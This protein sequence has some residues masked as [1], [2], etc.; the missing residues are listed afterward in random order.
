VLLA[1]CLGGRSSA[2]QYMGRVAEAADDGRLSLALAQQAGYPGAEAMALA[3]LSGAAWYSGDR[4]GAIRLAHQAQQ[5]RGEVP[6]ALYRA[7]SQILTMVLTG[8]GDLAAAEQVC[9]AGLTSCRDVG[10]LGNLCYQLWNRAILDLRAGRIEDATGHLHEQLQIAMQTGLGLGLLAGL[11]CCG[12]LCTATGRQA[13][14]VTVWAAMSTLAGPWPLP[15]GPA[16]PGEREGLLR[17]A[18]EQL[19]PARTRTA[20]ERGAALNLA[21]ATEYALMLATAAP[22]LPGAGPA[23][24]AGPATQAAAGLDKLSPRE[25]EL[26]TLVAQGRTDAQIAAQLYISARTVTSHLDRIRDKTGCR[27][28]ADL[29]RFALGAG[30]I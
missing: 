1:V 7:L 21:T 28:R 12:Y 29:T 13:E 14:A 11:D 25:R 9:T 8:A 23:P 10:D 30:L 20:E 4:D 19:G 24:A 22:Q 26:V 16:N 18:R 5:V 27:R 15:H 6:G 2:L 3:C 17:K